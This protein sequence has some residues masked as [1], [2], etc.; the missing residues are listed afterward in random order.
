MKLAAILLVSIGGVG[1]VVTYALMR[2][3]LEQLRRWH[4]EHD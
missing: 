4:E 1:L 2:R 3:R